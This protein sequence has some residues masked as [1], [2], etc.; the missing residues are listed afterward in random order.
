MEKEAACM[1]DGEKSGI[2]QLFM[3]MPQPWQSRGNRTAKEAAC[4]F[5]LIVQEDLYEEETLFYTSDEIEQAVRYHDIGFLKL[6]KAFLT[7]GPAALEEQKEAVWKHTVYGADMMKQYWLHHFLSEKEK[8]VWRMAAE[9]AIGHHE[10]WDGKGYPHGEMATAI[11]L[12]SRITAIVD[13]FDRVYQENDWSSERSAAAAIQRLEERAGTYYD[14]RLVTRFKEV[15]Y[16]S[17]KFARLLKQ[18]GR[19]E[20][21]ETRNKSEDRRVCG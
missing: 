1:N 5:E 9:T 21:S 7:A 2:D 18:E 16:H 6:P 3:T 12:I 14:P 13:C 15:C 8:E 11:S 4:F 20:Q 19:Q 17:E 10:R